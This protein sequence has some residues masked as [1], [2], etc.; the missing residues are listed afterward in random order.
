MNNI[1]KW[2]VNI[3]DGANNEHKITYL[4]AGGVST[5][6][7]DP[8]TPGMSSSGFYSGGNLI[9]N[10]PDK[11]FIP[12]AVKQRSVEYLNKCD[13]VYNCFLENYEKS[14]DKNDFVKRIDIIETFKYSD[15]YMNLDKKDKKNYKDKDIIQKL[16][17]RLV[18]IEET[19]INKIKYKNIIKG[20][21]PKMVEQ[22]EEHG[23]N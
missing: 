6:S 2:N 1:V 3:L 21:K 17:K 4:V 23:L 7:Y 15:F 12:D 8:M 9:K 5:Y 13:D 16:E 11:I 22:G 19:R 20:Y 18:F 14:D 10:A